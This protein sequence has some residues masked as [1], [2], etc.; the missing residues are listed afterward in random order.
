MQFRPLFFVFYINCVFVAYWIYYEASPYPSFDWLSSWF[1]CVAL[2]GGQNDCAESITLKY[3]DNFPGFTIMDVRFCCCSPS[4]LL[5][6]IHSYP[7]F[8]VGYE[9]RERRFSIL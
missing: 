7:L 5:C 9:Q 6:T 1:I 2:G 3:L 8:F 4:Q